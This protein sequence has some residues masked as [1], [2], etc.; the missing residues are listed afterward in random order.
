[1]VQHIGTSEEVR[2]SEDSIWALVR[3][4]IREAEFHLSQG[5]YSGVLAT[6]QRALNLV[7]IFSTQFKAIR[8]LILALSSPIAASTSGNEPSAILPTANTQ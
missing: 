4:L 8:H 6:L 2:E 3:S 1:M 7:P 5:N